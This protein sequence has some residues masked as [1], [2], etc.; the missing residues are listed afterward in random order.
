MTDRIAIIGAGI[1]GA[2]LAYRLALAGREVVVV[3][4]G[5]PGRATGWNPGGINPLH[6]PGFPGVMERFYRDA[7]RLHAEQQSQVRA[8]SGIDFGWRIVERLFLAADEEEA[9]QLRGLGDF[10]DALDGFDARWME[11]GEIAAW[12]SES[13]GP[14]PAG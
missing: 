7:F 6:G 2:C 14:G 12:D 5:R 10:Y 3:D 9:G 11:P 1:A 8:A 4:D 13:I